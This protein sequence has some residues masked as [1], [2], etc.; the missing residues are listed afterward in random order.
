MLFVS[1]EIIMKLKKNNFFETDTVAEKPVLN[2]ELQKKPESRLHTEKRI[3]PAPEVKKEKIRFIDSELK[4]LIEAVGEQCRQQKQTGLLSEVDMIRKYV[5]SVKFTVTV[6][7][8][9]SRG[10]STL[11]N[12]LIGNEIMPV[13]NLPTTAMLTKI[14]YNDTPVLVHINEKGRKTQLT[15]A[16]DSWDGLTADMNGNDAKGVV[17]AGIPDEWLL[18]NDMEFIDTPGAGDLQDKRMEYVDQAIMTSDCAILTIS[19]VNG[20]SLTEK[21][22]LEERILTRQVPRILLAVTKLDL[23]QKDERATVL[24]YINNKLKEWNVEVPVYITMEDMKDL[25]EG[26]GVGVGAMKEQLEFWAKDAGHLMRKNRTAYAALDEIVT[27]LQHNMETRLSM[28]DMEEGKRKDMAAKQ[29]E[30]IRNNELRWE[31][32][33]TQM[34]MR[35]NN[36]FDWMHQAIT[37]KQEAVIERIQYE[38]DRTMNPKEWWE[39]DYPYRLKME[40]VALGAGLE[41]G[42]QQLY[43]KDLAW[44]N[45]ILENDYKTNILQEKETM[46]EKELF[47]KW[48]APEDVELTD[49]KKGR[50]ISRIGTGVASA[51]GY[52]LFG[53]FGLSPLGAI[54]G[55]SGGILSELFLNRSIDA[56][57]R[58]LTDLV[59]TQVPKVIDQ[60]VMEVEQKLRK[61][62]DTV[63]NQAKQKEAAWIT[64]RFE[65]IDTALSQVDRSTEKAVREEYNKVMDL[66][67]RI[68]ITE[69]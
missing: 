57:K 43:V 28:Y 69:R 5:Q 56:Q 68:N 49:I 54:V 31:D 10:K 65:A 30:L 59:R 62:Y 52:L 36:N 13:G 35:C 67:S 17:Y 34:L 42:L 15:L 18:K 38:L 63:I 2:S 60:A 25:P 40:M 27:I 41:N 8:E 46:A 16:P 7:G 55:V 32:L 21:M 23:V 9:F 48:N 64:S 66:K 39:K 14:T 44:L 6:V 50:L 24:S 22:F 11:I 12:Q 19:A 29:K 26:I 37:E 3:A 20:L 51:G 61:A 58:K 47:K 53:A 4:E 1:K 33:Q 45:N